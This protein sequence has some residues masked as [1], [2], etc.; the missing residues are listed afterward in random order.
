MRIFLSLI[1]ISSIVFAYIDTDMDGVDDRVDQCPNSSIMDLVDING[2]SEEAFTSDYH[3]DIIL[4]GS[5]SQVD[6]ITNERTETLT[7]SLQVDYFKENFSLQLIGSYYKTSSFGYSESGLNDTLLAAYYLLPLSESFRV[8]LGAGVILPTYE[9]SLNNNNT[10]YLASASATYSVDDFNI[11]GAYSLTVINDDDIAGVANYQ[12][13][14]SYSLGLGYHTTS[15]NYISASYSQS[16][17]SII[18]IE[19]IQSVSIYDF[20]SINEHWFT[21]LSYA[22]GLS[23]SASDHYASINLGYYF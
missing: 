22:Y 8:R 10:D 3:Y 9:T 14:N 20:Y 12:D 4:G 5:Y 21:N 6:Y 1:L 15:R 7:S 13:T 16:Q 19:D 17:S 23:D 2:C 11:F 18:S